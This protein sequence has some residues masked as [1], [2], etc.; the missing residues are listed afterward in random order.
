MQLRDR[1]R[2]R[3]REERIVSVVNGETIVSVATKESKMEEKKQD[4]T[5]MEETWLSIPLFQASKN[6]DQVK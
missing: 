4:T 2:E 1:K 6:E 5:Q 3:R